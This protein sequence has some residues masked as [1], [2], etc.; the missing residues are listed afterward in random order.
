MAH[1]ISVL[2]SASDVGKS[3]VAAGLCRLLADAG[4]DVAPFK[5]QNMA[6]QAGVTRDGLEMPR[7]QIL[8]ALACRKEPHV[9]MGPV[10]LKPISHTGAQVI[11]LGKAVGVQEAQEYFRDANP[12]RE[13]AAAALA[14]LL[15]RHQVIVLEGAGSPVELNLMARDFANLVPARQANAA[16]ILVV[17][18]DKGGVFAQVEGTLGLLPDSDRARVLGIVVNR[19][20][21]DARL[22]DDGIRIIEER[23]GVPVLALLPYVEHGLDE[24]DHVF[25]MPINHRAPAGKLRVGAVL[26]PRVSN[27]EDLAPLLAE[28]D[29]ALTWL[30]DPALVLEQD[31]LILPGTKST[32]GDLAYLTTSGVAEAIR[33][34]ADRGVWI[35]GLCGGYQMLGKNLTDRAGSEGGPC[36]F[37]GLD[38]LP[39]ATV[40]EREKIVHQ[41]QTESL[42]PRPGHL[43]AGYEIHHGRTSLC[44]AGGEALVKADAE[45]GWKHRR[46]LGAYLHAILT[47]DGWRSDFLN[48]I[49][50]QRGLPTLE[51]QICESIELRLRRWAEHVKGHLRPGAWERVQGAVRTEAR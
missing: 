41:A 24:E 38:L 11:A 27:T 45:L 28:P 10:L 7:A 33:V 44:A 20:R 30:T 12:M 14:R 1:A 4:F 51:P 35:L 47:S 32:I 29:V 40:F 25:R 26:Y 21:G 34:A 8:Q 9:D 22:F 16:L 31:V 46:V 50:G 18:I 39:I 36:C 17:D 49:R 19:F 2:G 13:L 48:E 3:L 6:N 23:T 43:L 42:W 5:A 37:S 15:E